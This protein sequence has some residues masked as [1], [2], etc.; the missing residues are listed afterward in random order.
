MK[1]IFAVLF[2]FVMVLSFAACG[3]EEIPEKQEEL[4]PGM[5]E[6]TEETDRKALY[7]EIILTFGAKKDENGNYRPKGDFSFYRND[8]QYENFHDFGMDDDVLYGIGSMLGD[9]KREEVMAENYSYNA[10]PGDIFEDTAY[11]YF[12]IEPEPLRN[13]IHYNEI[14]GEGWYY[15]FGPVYITEDPVINIERTEENGD[16]VVFYLFIDYE[17]DEEDK[18]R[19]LTVKLLPEG[20]FNYISYVEYSGEAENLSYKFKLGPNGEE[21]EISVG[22]TIGEWVLESISGNE[23]DGIEAV[24]KGA[25]QADCLIYENRMTSDEPMYLFEAINGDEDKFP[26]FAGDE[27]LDITFAAKES[28]IKGEIP[29]FYGS[30]I[31]FGYVVTE[32]HYNFLPM[33]VLSMAKLEVSERFAAIETK[34]PELIAEHIFALN[35]VEDDNFGAETKD[36][37]F[38]MLYKT[39][40]GPGAFDKQPDAIVARE[41]AKSEKYSG[42]F[43]NQMIEECREITNF[44]TEDEIKEYL[45]GYLAPELFDTDALKIHIIEFGGKA[46]RVWYSR[47]YGVKS[48]GNSEITSQTENEMTAKAYIYHVGCEEAGTAELEFEKRGENWI[49]VSVTDSYYRDND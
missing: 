20:G 40:P 7:D 17:N 12:G 25:V 33:S 35:E 9:E 46:Y 24:F 14:D 42:W 1:K 37:Y 48:Y 32:Y 47:G 3:N 44:K 28:D 2:A 41:E 23:N 49:L 38:T 22:D 45:G 16:L 11:K 15:P 29:E 34:E 10:F 13:T 26:V 30:K 5:E 6:P 8:M 4:I 27:C 21:T 19:K 36:E 43:E 39:D 31:C 18:Q